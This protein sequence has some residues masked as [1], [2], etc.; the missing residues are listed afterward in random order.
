MVQAAEDLGV[1][2]EVEAG[3]VEE[4]QQVAVTHVE[5]EMVGPRIVTVLDDLGQ[6]K[7]EDALVEADRLRH[8]RAEQRGVMD[9]ARAASRP[10]SM[11]VFGPQPRALRLDNGEVHVRHSP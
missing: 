10:V 9:S 5:E 2:A 4:G 6:R 1:R 7:L 8:V 11:Y 3:K